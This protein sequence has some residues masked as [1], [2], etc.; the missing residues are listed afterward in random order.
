MNIIIKTLIAVLLAT[1]AGHPI[2]K[3]QTK[4]IIIRIESDSA[5]RDSIALD[6]MMKKMEISLKKI[7]SKLDKLEN[8]E[9]EIQVDERDIDTWTINA[10]RIVSRTRIE[11]ITQEF[12]HN[13]GFLYVEQNPSA[14]NTQTTA[15]GVIT[16]GMPE[17]NA[18]KSLHY[19]LEQLWGLNLIKGKLRLFTGLRY[20][21][22]NFRF[23]SNFVRLTENATEFQAI[24]VGGP[25][26][27]PIPMDKSKLVANYIGIPVAIGYQSNPGHWRTSYSDGSSTDFSETP[28]FA[29]KAGIHTGYRVSSHAKLKE[30]GGNTTKQYD[31]FNLNNF[32]VAPFIQLEY[33]DVGLYMRY[34][35][36]HIFKKGQGAEGQCIQ[37]GI[38]LKFT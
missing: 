36:T 7:E 27:D 24:T 18:A 29:I 8:I 23:Q 32:I 15:G 4:K 20:D 31:D 30:S 38:T 3:A 17:L 5:K 34:P 25:N 12:H 21:L 16:N 14:V 26:V 19:G 10:P 28:K 1:L 6:S 37:L 11:P 9:M 22:Y 35:I 33:E 2:A 13:I